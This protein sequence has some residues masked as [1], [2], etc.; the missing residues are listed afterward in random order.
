MPVGDLC[1]PTWANGYF[2]PTEDRRNQSS[3]S[4]Q[5]KEARPDTPAAALG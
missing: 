5:S 3:P 4:V 1:D 2:W